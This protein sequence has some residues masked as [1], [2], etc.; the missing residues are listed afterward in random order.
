M[1]YNPTNMQIKQQFDS[2]TLKKMGVSA[3]L[4]IG[5]A[6][7]TYISDNLLQFIGAVG[8]PDT[9]KPFALSLFTWLINAGKEF[10]KGKE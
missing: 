5:G 7:L 8:I 4:L 3:L 6:L 1:E 9:W 10:I 2:V